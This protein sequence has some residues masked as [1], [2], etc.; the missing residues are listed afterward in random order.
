MSQL[1]IKFQR[2]FISLFIVNL[3]FF[4]SCGSDKDDGNSRIK[5]YSENTSYWQYKG[6]PVYLLGGNKVVNPFQ[7]EHDELLNYLDELQLSG[8][9]FFR[10]VMSDREP[11]NIKAFERLKNG[12]YD[13]T[14]WNKD[15]WDGLGNM[16]KWS[17]ERDIIVNLTF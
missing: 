5:P 2:M 3:I 16:L 13:L 11:G 8:G 17:Y 7:L 12:K 6:M 4:A 14:K 1:N 9:N 15:Y 10:N